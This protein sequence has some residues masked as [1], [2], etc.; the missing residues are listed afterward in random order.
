MDRG[1]KQNLLH[2][3][4]EGEPVYLAY[5]LNTGISKE[6]LQ[7]VLP[8]FRDD[9]IEDYYIRNYP[10][11]LDYYFEEAL[12]KPFLTWIED[13]QAWDMLEGDL[14]DLMVRKT[15]LNVDGEVLSD[16]EYYL[17]D[18]DRD[19]IWVEDDWDKLTDT[20]TDI[21]YYG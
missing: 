16:Y 19:F 18:F 6:E 2:Y 7:R 13:N 10:L 1:V 4:R 8:K 11:F 3:L 12:N 20:L 15:W 21:Y 9:L 17:Y 14:R 5:V